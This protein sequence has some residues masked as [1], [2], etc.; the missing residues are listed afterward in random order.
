[1]RKHFRSSLFPRESESL[2]TMFSSGGLFYHP[3]PA[4]G[5]GPISL[6]EQRRTEHGSRKKAAEA[7]FGER[8]D[9]RGK[10]KA[11]IEDLKREGEGR[12]LYFAGN[13]VTT[14]KETGAKT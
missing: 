7:S 12:K 3:W 6:S 9:F 2:K 10:K 8:K 4:P 11:R 13:E 1:M 14:R 5:F